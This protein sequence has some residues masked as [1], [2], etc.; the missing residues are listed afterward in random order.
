M[1]LEPLLIA[2]TILWFVVGILVC[3]RLHYVNKSKRYRAELV[4]QIAEAPKRIMAAY[5]DGYRIGYDRSVRIFTDHS[6]Q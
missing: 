1:G 5:E 2:M 3:V 4:A 6:T